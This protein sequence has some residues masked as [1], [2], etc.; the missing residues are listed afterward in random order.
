MQRK[1]IPR[2]IA[3][4][5]ILRCMLLN[6]NDHFRTSFQ[7]YKIEENRYQSLLAALLDNGIIRRID[8]ESCYTD[9]YSISDIVKYYEWS[10]SGFYRAIEKYVI[11]FVGIAKAGQELVH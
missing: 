9:A 8:S 4:T 10:K 11:P 3:D 7:D 5:N 1:H 6:I 2:T